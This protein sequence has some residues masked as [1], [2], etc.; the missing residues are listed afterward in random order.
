MKKIHIVQLILFSCTIFSAC[1]QNRHNPSLEY[2]QEDV[3]KLFQWGDSIRLFLSPNYHEDDIIPFTTESGDIE[4]M[5]VET[6]GSLTSY[7][8]IENENGN[9]DEMSGKP[10][11]GFTNKWSG[12]VTVN[13][14]LKRN[15]L[16]AWDN[17][18]IEIAFSNTIGGKS[19]EFMTCTNNN[20]DQSTTI[21]LS[22]D[23]YT[24]YM[25]SEGCSCTLRKNIGITFMSDGQGHTW[26]R[27]ED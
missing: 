19:S 6:V 22:D 20:H 12:I 13:L 5:K 1:E 18:V 17:K 9:W 2:N 23:E 24:L 27:P 7:V 26:T 3:K 11:P 21:D 8:S 10:E 15:Y 4:W 16:D 25:K 14:C